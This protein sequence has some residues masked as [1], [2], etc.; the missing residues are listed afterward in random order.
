MPHGREQLTAVARD[1]ARS[2][3]AVWNL[4]YSR[5]GAGGGWPVTAED[6]SAGIDHLMALSEDGCDLDLGRV[7]LVGH[8]AGGHLALCE[9]GRR[10]DG[11]GAGRIQLRAVV[12]L[13]PLAD[14]IRAH[15]LR[16]GGDV[17][18]EFVGASPRERPGLYRAASP[19]EMLPLGVRQVI[20]H[21]TADDTVPIELS[22]H[23]VHAAEAAG[24]SAELV[25]LTGG[26][27]MDFLEPTSEAHA[28]MRERLT[29]ILLDA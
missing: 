6:V 19:A 9:G 13:A 14:L 1:L 22:R 17:V 24:D 12:G 4:G 5:L 7:A 29:T 25:E 28:N 8:S 10:R 21:G 16:V 20:L 11:I 15:D 2:G 18:A 27:H 26:G 23:Y 3:L